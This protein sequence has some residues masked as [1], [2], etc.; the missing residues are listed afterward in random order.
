MT[1]NWRT[2]DADLEEFFAAVYALWLIA[3]GK[4][5]NNAEAVRSAVT[6]EN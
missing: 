1:D 6:G 3:E 4:K 2:P 5:Q